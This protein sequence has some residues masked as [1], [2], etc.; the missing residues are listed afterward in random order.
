M[1]I[2]DQIWT[3]TEHKFVQTLIVCICINTSSPSKEEVLAFLEGY[4][5]VEAVRP[6]R[7]S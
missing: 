6:V 4:S 2:K 5:H 7:S 1:D 3:K